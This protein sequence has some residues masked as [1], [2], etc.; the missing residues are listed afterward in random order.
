MEIIKI[1]IK[2]GKKL[3][4]VCT[5]FFADIISKYVQINLFFFTKYSPNHNKKDRK[6]AVSHL[7]QICILLMPLYLIDD[8]CRILWA[9][10][11]IERLAESYNLIPRTNSF[12]NKNIK[13]VF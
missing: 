9:T 3:V 8:H 4:V 7:D 13:F 5:H 12:V 10:G 2:K 11:M 6:H 1:I